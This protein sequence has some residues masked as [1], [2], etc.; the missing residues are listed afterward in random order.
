MRSAGN[1]AALGFCWEDH[2]LGVWQPMKQA[3]L[4]LQLVITVVSF[5]LLRQGWRPVLSWL[6]LAFMM[7]QS[8]KK[9]P[10]HLPQLSQWL[11][12]IFMVQDMV[13][14]AITA[15]NMMRM[16]RKPLGIVR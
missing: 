16:P 5:H 7:D 1:V 8:Q 11:K 13:L 6:I 14:T 2:L 12:R 3:A 10:A 4:P 9:G 15:A